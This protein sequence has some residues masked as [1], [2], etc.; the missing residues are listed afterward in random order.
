MKEK[1]VLLP[2]KLK[3]LQTETFYLANNSSWQIMKIFKANI[4]VT[5]TRQR[6]RLNKQ[7]K[8]L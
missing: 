5:A 7:D 2:L 4:S 1:N 8:N 6:N 3:S